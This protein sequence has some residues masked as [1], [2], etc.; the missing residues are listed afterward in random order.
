MAMATTMY[1]SRKN[2]LRKVSQD[3]ETVETA[4]SG[5]VRKFHKALLRWHDPDNW[6]IIREGLTAMGR[7]DLIGNRPTQL[8]PRHQPAGGT[9]GRVGA[10]PRAR[11][12]VEQKPPP[13]PGVGRKARGAPR[14]L[15]RI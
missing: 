8:V 3:S 6:S 11:C 2:P 13:T 12:A 1:H 15:K 14:P 5:K 9:T 10:Q 4:R 7:A